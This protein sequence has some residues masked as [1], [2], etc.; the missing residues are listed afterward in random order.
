MKEKLFFKNSRGNKLCAIL[1]NPTSDKSKPVIILCHGFATS[2]DGFTFTRLEEILGRKGISTFRFDFFGH[3]ESEGKLEEITASE[4][5]DDIL[6]ALEFLQNKGY[7]KI[8]LVGSSFGGFASLIAASKT[9]GFYLLALKSPV[10]DYKGFISSQQNREEI[11][12]WKEKGFMD[13]A[14]ADGQKVKINYAFFED[15]EK[16]S[17]YDAA[18]KIK[19]P[20]LIVH[21][22]SDKVVPVGQSKKLATL[23]R[24]SSLKIIKG[25]DHRY[26]K[27]EDFEKMLQLVSDFIIKNS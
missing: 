20:A 16:I 19:V 23:I 1:S 2:K 8:G 15:A 14:A 12:K 11:E 10:S 25:A 24:S 13:Y 26:S 21:G 7:V 27:P 5:V 9:A 22:D 17:G 6:K 18:R 3:G 4:A